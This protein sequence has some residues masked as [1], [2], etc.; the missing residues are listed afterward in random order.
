MTTPTKI[1]LGVLTAATVAIAL[2]LGGYLSKPAL[3]EGF[4]SGNG[5]V[6][7]TEVD[8]ATKLPGRIAEL[9]AEEGDMIEKGTLLARLD[10]RELEA[11]LRQGE[12]QLNQARQQKQYAEA[13]VTQRLSEYDLAAKNLERSKSLY[14]NK[15]ISLVQ[16][17]QHET[18]FKSAE[19]AIAAAKAQVTS[20][21]S[22]IVAAAA[23]VDTIRTNLD[24]SNLYAPIAGRVLYRLAEPGEVVGSG[25]RLFTLLDPT[26]VFM[27]I[28]LP[29][30][31]AGR[32]TVGS[33]ARIV[34]DA[35]PDRPIPAYVS[36]VSPE[37]QFTPKEIETVTEREKLMFRIKVK[38]DP[39]RIKPHV[40]AVKSGLPGVAY[41][42]LDDTVPWPETLRVDPSGKKPQ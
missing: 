17:Q 42:R 26:D 7:A 35:L 11:R 21:Q 25:S 36:F 27:T 39:E 20:A 13:I 15:S 2:W 14:V 37:A 18:A 12:A 30:S 24:D 16:L 22:A 19:A 34:I 4:A 10:A 38:I 5:R 3:P 8:V 6:E 33:E 9:F 40:N 29:T 23:Q 28:F 31:Q 1:T 41:V 32:V